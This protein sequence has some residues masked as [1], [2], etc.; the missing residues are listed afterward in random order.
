MGGVEEGDL[1]VGA[2][3]DVSWVEAGWGQ[4][5]DRKTCFVPN[6]KGDRLTTCDIERAIGAPI[7]VAIV[8]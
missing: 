1:E 3:G 8:M 5:T 6:R 4:E 2:G 7:S